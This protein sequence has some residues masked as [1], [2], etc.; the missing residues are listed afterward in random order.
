MHELVKGNKKSSSRAA[1]ILT[2][3][4]I[5]TTY[6]I[7]LYIPEAQQFYILEFFFRFYFCVKFMVYHILYI[8]IPYYYINSILY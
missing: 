7:V 3:C 4:N 6:Y 1:K 2:T 8:L 5:H